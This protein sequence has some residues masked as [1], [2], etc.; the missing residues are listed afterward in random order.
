MAYIV[1]AH[2]VMTYEVVACIARADVVMADEV[3]ATGLLPES[4]VFRRVLS[5]AVRHA[6]TS[7]TDSPQVCVWTGA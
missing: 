6:G 2:M 7:E 1:M 5:H 4:G 3:M